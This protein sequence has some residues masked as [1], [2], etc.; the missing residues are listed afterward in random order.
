MNLTQK[1]LFANVRALGMVATKTECGEYRVAFHGSN[2]VTEPSAYYTP[3]REDAL[4]TGLAMAGNPTCPLAAEA[5]A[6][7]ALR[8]AP[9]NAAMVAR[10]DAQ[11][12]SPARAEAHPTCPARAEFEAARRAWINDDEPGVPQPTKAWARFVRAAA[13]LPTP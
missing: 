2:A 7:V 5:R 10:L 8:A 11:F 13:A 9:E 6:I 12:D 4:V 1:A 3:C